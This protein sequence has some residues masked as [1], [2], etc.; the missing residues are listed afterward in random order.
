LL[1]CVI[2]TVME[3]KDK[4]YQLTWIAAVKERGFGHSM[5]TM[6]DVLEPVAPL[7]AQF[8]WVLQPF[9]GLFGARNAVH[10]L[11]HLLD[12]PDGVATLR[13]QLHDDKDN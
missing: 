13:Q 9:A 8:L 5:Q 11:A 10:D 4:H 2:L 6:L 12:T 1:R 7:A 3:T